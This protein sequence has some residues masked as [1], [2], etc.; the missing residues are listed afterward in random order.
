MGRSSIKNQVETA[1]KEINRIGSSKREAKQGGDTSNIHSIK[2]FRDALGTGI[3]FA[4]FC[5]VEYGIRSIYRLTEEHTK[6]YLNTLRDK[7]VSQG[8]LINV[9]SHLCKLQVGMQKFSEKIGKPPVKFINQ[10]HI[11]PKQREIPKDRSYSQ[12][13]ILKLEKAMSPAVRVAMQMSLQLGLRAKEAINIRVE[14]IIQRENGQLQ[15]HIEQGRGITKGG[16]YRDI[17]VPIAYEK[18]LRQLIQGKEA[19]QKILGGIKEGTLRSGLKRACDRSGVVSFGWH[20]F[21]HTYARTRL[22]ELLGDRQA[23]GKIIIER[24]L[25][26]RANGRKVHTGISSSEKE[27]F[28]VVKESINTVH[29][30]LGHGDNRWGLVAVY[31]S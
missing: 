13:E 16:R 20:G 21:R 29:H 24:M 30:E 3:R 2:Y 23:Q 7:G 11:S 15:V 17:P 27:L 9:E 18:P 10:R 6:G 28:N 8:Y 12:E 1:L 31:M 14:H 19:T 25:E 5:R 22:S 26:N 4:E